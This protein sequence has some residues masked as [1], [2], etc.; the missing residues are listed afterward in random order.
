MQQEYLFVHCSEMTTNHDYG[1]AL[2]Y[3]SLILIYLCML[4]K[5]ADVF[6]CGWIISVGCLLAVLSLGIYLL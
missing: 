3:I 5:L 6:K 1:L 2:I 4:F